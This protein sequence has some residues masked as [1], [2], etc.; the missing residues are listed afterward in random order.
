MSHIKSM[1]IIF[2]LTVA[3]T[4]FFKSEESLTI[5]NPLWSFLIKQ[6]IKKIKMNNTDKKICSYQQDFYC[7]SWV[8]WS[9]KLEASLLSTEENMA[10]KFS[11]SER[12]SHFSQA[13][14]WS[15][16]ASFFSPL[17][18]LSFWAHPISLYFFPYRVST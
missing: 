13:V 4:F 16:Y 8:L 3:I 2:D 12:Q 9:S 1:H 10:Y 18:T 11:D 5:E 6:Q 7:L 14:P 17:K 15:R